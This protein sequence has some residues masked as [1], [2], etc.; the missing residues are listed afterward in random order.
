MQ[1]P[2]ARRDHPTGRAASGGALA[3]EPPRATRRQPEF[4]RTVHLVQGFFPRFFQV[5]PVPYWEAGRGRASKGSG[6]QSEFNINEI[7][8]N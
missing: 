7:E 6:P 4:I 1:V 8:L 2:W 5:E 3:P